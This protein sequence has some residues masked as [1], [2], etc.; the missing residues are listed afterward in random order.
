MGLLDSVLG[1]V[2]G[3][4]QGQGQSGG[5]ADL[6]RAVIG[7]LGNDG[8]H[9]GLEGLVRQFTQ[10]GLGDVVQSWISSGQ[11][12]PVSAD[13][14]QGVLGDERIGAMAQQLGLNPGDLAG[15][16]SQVLPQVVDQ[17]TP[18]GQMP[19]GGLGN[20]AD[21]LGQLMRR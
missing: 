20:V 9:G 6:V 17:L 10:G 4:M 18:Q 5:G 2:M 8:A 16:L 1:G 21:L 3:A 13:Q 14:L 19:K 7:M 15:Q 12:L 11:N